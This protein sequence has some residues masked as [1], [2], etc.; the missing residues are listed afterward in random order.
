MCGKEDY[1][2][3]T[4]N[5]FEGWEPVRLYLEG[6]AQSVG[7]DGKKV[8]EI[9]G[10]GMYSHWFTKSQWGFIPQK[11]YDKLQAYYNGK[12]FTK[13]YEELDAEF[14]KAKAE[15]ERIKQEWYATR[16]YF[17]NTHDKMTDVWE[18]G[19]TRGE[20]RA[21]C[22]DHATPK[23]L[24]LCARGIKTSSREGEIV[25]DVFG[26]SGSTMIACEQLGRKCRMMELDPH[27]CTVIIARW[28]K[29]TGQKA[30]KL[31]Q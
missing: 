27:Y 3:N 18:F 12:A 11:H 15:F 25:L 22:G 2:I 28:E 24:A 14:K 7:L 17:D 31:N 16:A 5:Y 10:V 1:N 21:E 13:S 9:C 6:E 30:I 19:R 20:E 23:P 29:L 4:D 26:G 8:E